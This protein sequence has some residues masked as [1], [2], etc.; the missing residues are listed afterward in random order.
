V[1]NAILDGTDCVMLS[2]ETAVG[3]YPEDA[4][5][6]MAAIARVTEQERE[7]HFLARL[8]QLEKVR[9]EIRR[10]DLVSLTVYLDVETMKPGVVLIPSRSGATARRV[11]RFRLPIWIVAVSED[12]AVCQRMQFSY[13][14]FPVCTEDPP[15]WSHFAVDWV[16]QYVPAAEVVLLTREGDARRERDSTLIEIIDLRPS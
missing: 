2:G 13:G 14:V 12:E 5:A 1:A 10:E 9:G 11:S 6:A 16:R 8:L 7:D 15:N 4:V 3:E